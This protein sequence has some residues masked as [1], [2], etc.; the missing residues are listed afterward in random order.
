MYRCDRCLRVTGE[1]SIYKP[2]DEPEVSAGWTIP[3]HRHYGPTDLCEDCGKD[4][5]AW[6]EAGK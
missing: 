5:D 6:V 4:F 3:S 1:S 2:S